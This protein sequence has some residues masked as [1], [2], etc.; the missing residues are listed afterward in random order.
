LLS[1]LE[2]VY[3]K[4]LQSTD[5]TLTA[6][7]NAAAAG[8]NALERPS[9]SFFERNLNVWRQLWRVTET[10]SIIL[11]LIDSRFPLIHFPPSL[12]AYVKQLGKPYILVLTKTDLVPRWLA[13]AW[14]SWFLDRA[15]DQD[16]ANFIDCV[17]M[18]SYREIAPNALTQGT[19]PRYMPAAPTSARAA[20]LAAFR[21]AHNRLLSV[22]EGVTKEREGEDEKKRAERIA[23]WTP[24]VRREVDWESVED[25]KTVAALLKA[26]EDAKHAEDLAKR[27][28]KTAE[29]KKTRRKQDRDVFVLKPTFHQQKEMDA[30]EAAAKQA[31]KARHEAEQDEAEAERNGEQEGEYNPNKGKNPLE[32]MTGDDAHPFITIGLI[33]QPNVGKSSLLNALLGKKVVRASRTPGKT[34]TLQTIVSQN[35]QFSR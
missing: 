14:Q 29:K 33:G 9:P 17:M 22:P 12:E 32:G 1:D 19:Q 30:K 35:L 7:T 11:I 24:H 31:S 2:G 6:F 8:P 20:L 28:E 16:D 23:R 13:E 21:R 26:K 34:K 10:S 3:N 4:W 25:E 5:S 18:T 15:V 27:K